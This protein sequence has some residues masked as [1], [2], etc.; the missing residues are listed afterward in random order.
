MEKHTTWVVVADGAQARFL[1]TEG[2]GK[3][4]HPVMN[5]IRGTTARAQE[6]GLNQPERIFEQGGPSGHAS[7][8]SDPKSQA[9]A[10][11][12]R[13]VA[14][15][16]K[17]ES[18][19]GCFDRLVLVAP[20]KAL[21]IFRNELAGPVKSKVTAEVNKDLTNVPEHQLGSHLSDAVAF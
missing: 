7:P 3:G 8:S 16:L 13:E 2:P 12:I 9:E 21:G 17:T 10:M 6:G 5:E 14:Q 18:D 1:Q 4:L 20:D 11:F 19:R 15:R